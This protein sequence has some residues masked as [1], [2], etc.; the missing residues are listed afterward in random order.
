MLLLT[1]YISTCISPALL[2]FEEHCTFPFQLAEHLKINK[3]HLQILQLPVDLTTSL[4]GKKG[5]VTGF[6]ACQ[7]SV[8][9]NGT[10]KIVESKTF[11]GKLRSAKV[12]IIDRNQCPKIPTGKGES[13]L[14]D[15]HFLAKMMKKSRDVFGFCYVSSIFLLNCISSTFP[16]STFVYRAT[17]VVPLF[18]RLKLY[19]E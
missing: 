13:R 8:S 1:Y 11:D 9:L 18:T 4:I 16:F 17:V 7:V 12:E 19:L 2:T 5:V 15:Y 10:R 14:R 6:G 3:N